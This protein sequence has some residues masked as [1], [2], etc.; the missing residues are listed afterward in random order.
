MI[1]QTIPAIRKANLG[2]GI[3]TKAQTKVEG[4]SDIEEED[5]TKTRESETKT[6][7]SKTQ[8]EATTDVSLK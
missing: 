3:G 5:K 1:I 7:E 4:Y 6:K 8:K 2:P